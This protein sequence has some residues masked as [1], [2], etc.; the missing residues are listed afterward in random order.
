MKKNN[1]PYDLSGK[2]AMIT[3]GSRGIGE[4]IARLF[5]EAGAHVIIS[6]RKPADCQKVADDINKQGGSAEALQCHTGNM[7]DIRNAFEAISG[8]HSRLD[9]MVN[10]AATNP[11][12]GSVLDIDEGAYQKTLDVNLKGPF[13]CSQYAAKLMPSEGGS[14]LNISSVGGIRPTP[15]QTVYGV[16]KAALIHLTK[17]LA[18]ELGPKKIRVNAILPGLIKTKFASALFENKE[19]YDD[20][21]KMAPLAPYSQPQTIAEAALHL[22][23]DAAGFTTGECMV[24][25]G[26]AAL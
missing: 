24:V 2:I 25:D 13:F 21:V 4:A 14:I 16:T 6:S 1:R 9:I 11:F 5:A 15:M 7:D 20:F 8:A 3:G 23:S 19:M 22:V 18:V 10:N 17:C 26:G 12:F